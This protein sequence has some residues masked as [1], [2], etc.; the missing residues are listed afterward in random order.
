MGTYSLGIRHHLNHVAHILHSGDKLPDYAVR[1]VQL[2]KNLD[3]PPVRASTNGPLTWLSILGCSMSVVLVIL[4]VHYDDG[5]ALLATILLSF[6]STL[7]AAG[8]KWTL[9]LPK[10]KSDREVPPGDVVIYYPQGAFM[11][12]KCDEDIARE[13]YWAPEKCN[14]MVGVQIYRL[15]ALTGTIMLMFGV[16]ALANTKLIL[17][18]AFAC[19]YIILN[20]AYWI[21]AALPPKLHWEL[22]SFDVRPELY[23]GGEENKNFTQALWKAIA[24]AGSTKWARVGDIAPH[25]TFWD[26]WLRKADEVLKEYDNGVQKRDE[27][28]DLLLPEWDCQK[29]LSEFLAQDL[30]EKVG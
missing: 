9:E 29:A 5:W 1:C 16:I 15:I 8:S 11:V 7:I 28:G 6:L 17:Q 20:A 14:Y 27:N 3:I 18:I 22:K 2:T 4:S 23:F 30:A 19:A 21:V 24:I 12:I 26:K 13:L 10:R 25:A